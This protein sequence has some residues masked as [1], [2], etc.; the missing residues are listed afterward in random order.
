MA[1]EAIDAWSDSDDDNDVPSE[2]ETSVLL[3]TPDGPITSSSDIKDA[4]VSR[5]GGRPVR[6]NVPSL[7]SNRIFDLFCI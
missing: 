5:I 7:H 6:V 1:P 2:V 4:A 3:G